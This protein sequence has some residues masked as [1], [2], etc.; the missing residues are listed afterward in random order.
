MLDAMRRHSQSFLI[1]ILFGAIISVFLVSFGPGRQG[2]STDFTYAA[3]VNSDTISEEEFR[4]TFSEQLRYFQQGSA[5]GLTPE[6]IKQLGLKKQVLDQLIDTKLLAQAAQQAHLVVSEDELRQLILQA[7]AFQVNG[8]FDYTAYERYVKYAADT[9]PARFEADLREKMLAEKFRHVIEVS[10]SVSDAD[11][12]TDYVQNNDKADLYFVEISAQNAPGVEVPSAAE[13]EAYEKAHEAEITARYKRDELR[14]HEPKKYKARHILLKVADKAS[15]QEV[16]AVKIKIEAIAKEIAAGKDFSQLAQK[17]SEDSSKDK[18]G[19]VGW[20]GPGMM[21]KPFEEAVSQ[22]KIGEVSKP[23]RSPFGFHLIK[24]DEVKEAQNRELPQVHRDI[25][26]ELVLEQRRDQAAHSEAQRILALV[27]NGKSIKD[28]F[29]PESETETGNSLKGVRYKTTGMFNHGVSA[30]PKIGFNDELLR[31]AFAA[32][33]EQ[34][35]LDKVYKLG[36]RYV[37]AEIKERQLPDMQK[38]EKDRKELRTQTLSHKKDL[39][40]R[41]YLKHQREVSDIKINQRIVN[42]E[43]QVQG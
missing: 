19:D 40:V 23:V 31:D 38:F 25:A 41:D 20:F 1:Y 43:P 13:I 17:Y 42:D 16:D 4:R 26:Q 14:Y 11:L 8:Q 5:K 22:L 10:V 39:I 36:N 24:L 7:P 30:I 2:C 12:R 32:K 6:L 9:S 21:V 15:P 33:P 29:S 18:G 3:K 27:K 34:R 35:L 28:L 37:V